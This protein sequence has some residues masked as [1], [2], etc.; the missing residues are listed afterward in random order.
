LLRAGHYRQAGV[1]HR[2]ASSRFIA[3]DRDHVRLGT[4][5]GELALLDDLGEVW[6][7]RQKAVAGMH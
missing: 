5:K 4:N 3:H 7:F 1:A 6:I 2:G